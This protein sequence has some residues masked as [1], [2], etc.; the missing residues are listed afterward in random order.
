VNTDGTRF[1]GQDVLEDDLN[2]IVSVGSRVFVPEADHVTKLV[3][4]DAELVAVLADRDRLRTVAA[5]SHERT[6][7]AP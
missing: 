4:D 1:T 5:L 6:A 3:H 7:P 2:V